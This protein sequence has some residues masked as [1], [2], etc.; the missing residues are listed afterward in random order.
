MST[1][2]R[3][4][5]S[6]SALRANDF[7]GCYFDIRQRWIWL[8]HRWRER[9]LLFRA[10]LHLTIIVR[11]VM[12]H[13]IAPYV[14]ICRS[15][16]CSFH[17]L[18]MVVLRAISDRSNLDLFLIVYLSLSVRDSEPSPDIPHRS[19]PV[20]SSCTQSYTYIVYPRIGLCTCGIWWC[21]NVRTWDR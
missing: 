5:T 17:T 9:F 8:F 11:T 4:T 20:S 3:L 12:D 21:C 13:M 14:C 15:I 16:L 7:C 18:N 10:W 1:T 6:T 19:S 2:S